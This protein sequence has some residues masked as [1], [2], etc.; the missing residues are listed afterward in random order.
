VHSPQILQLSGIG[1]RKLLE[2][3]EIEIVVDLPGV[4]RNF[5]DHPTLYAAWNCKFFWHQLRTGS[6][7]R[8]IADLILCTSVQVQP[9]PNINELSANKTYADEQ[10]AL[11]FSKRQGPYTIVNQ[12]GNTVAFLPLPN[13]TTSYPSIIAL[14]NLQRNSIYGSSLPPT[15]LAGYLTQRNLVLDLYASPDASVQETGWNG[16]AVLPITLVKPLSRGSVTINST[17]ILS[18]PFI[19]WGALTYPSDIEIL[20]ASL[21]KNREFI[22]SAPMQELY[23]VELSP[24]AELVE[25]EELR[26]ALRGLVTPT[27]SHPCCT[28]AMMPRRLGGVVGADLRVHGTV[29]LRVVDAGIMP[30]IPG[31]HTSA[32][33]YAVAEKAAD[34]IKECWEAE[35]K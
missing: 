19:D 18:P 6:E 28:C 8:R 9:N 20:M 35:E 31:T 33:V 22:A 12:G 15:V 23:P 26:T 25:D 3:L 13:I 17:S 27:Y 7:D 11:Y 30:L 16:G 14:A 1:D 4:G 29:G 5:Q 10:L 24:G 2:S 21:R 34:L 32:T